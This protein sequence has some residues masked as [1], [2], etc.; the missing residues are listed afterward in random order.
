MLD[1]NCLDQ[2]F[3]GNIVEA[4]E[5]AFRLFRGSG[6]E[7]FILRSMSVS[8][9][10]LM[11]QSVIIIKLPKSYAAAVTMSQLLGSMQRLAKRFHKKPTILERVI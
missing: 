11:M 8:A 4:I 2:V 3:H 5:A 1:F 10:Y 9:I 7:T 6:E